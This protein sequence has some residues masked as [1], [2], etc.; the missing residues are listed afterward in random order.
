MNDKLYLIRTWI[1]NE[2][3]I[4]DVKIEKETLKQ[5]KISGK[6]VFRK[7]INKD[8][9]YKILDNSVFGFDLNKCK[10]EWNKHI[11][12]RIEIKKETIEKLR[13]QLF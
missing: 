3:I 12:N 10:S 9:L 13:K 6:K 7:T 2:S 11:E 4:I 5:Y 8:D 1:N